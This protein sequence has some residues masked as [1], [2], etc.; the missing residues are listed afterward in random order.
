M[1]KCLNHA[2]AIHKCVCVGVGLFVCLWALFKHANSKLLSNV[3][4]CRVVQFFVSFPT[5]LVCVRR[6]EVK[7]KRL[8]GEQ[9]S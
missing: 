3:A 8:E 6:Q 9:T 4:F 1:H 7:Q 2:N 5:F